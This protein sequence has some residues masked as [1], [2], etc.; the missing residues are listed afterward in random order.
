MAQMRLDSYCSLDCV[1]RKVVHDVYYVRHVNPALDI[2][3][4]VLT[5]WRLFKELSSFFWKCFVLPSPEEIERGFHDAVGI[6]ED[7]PA[8]SHVA[9][10]SISTAPGSE[11]D[12]VEYR[13]LAE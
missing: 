10:M 5:G 8:I 2:K 1:Q 9:L 3:L 6:V 11:T 4:L 12:K 7:E 13:D